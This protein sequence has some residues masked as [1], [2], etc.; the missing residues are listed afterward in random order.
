VSTPLT[1]FYTKKT[2]GKDKIIKPIRPKTKICSGLGR[3]YTHAF[4]LLH[5]NLSFRNES[6]GGK[7]KYVCT[8]HPNHHPKSLQD[9]NRNFNP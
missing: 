5:K 6:E 4:H 3:Y 2:K 7:L 8:I 9:S 1:L